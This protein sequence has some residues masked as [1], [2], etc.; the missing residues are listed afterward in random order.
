MLAGLLALLVGYVSYNLGVTYI[1]SYFDD[2]EV[3]RK[4]QLQYLEDL[5][6]FIHENDV[7]V[8]NISKIQ[9]WVADNSYV[10]LSIYRNQKIIYNSDSIYDD[11]S[12]DDTSESE[13]EYSDQDGNA[14]EQEEDS[15]EYL[16]PIVLK[17]SNVVNVDIFCYDYWKYNY[18]ILGMALVFAT[19]VF[20][21]VLTML[22]HRK[23]RYINEI[24]KELQILEGGNL[25]YPITIKGKDEIANLAC[26]IEQM[27]ISIIENIEKEQQ[28]LR[29][30][31]E[32]V[33][34]M[35]H[36]LR[37]PLTILTGYLEMLNMGNIVDEEKRKHYLELSLLKSQEIRQLSDDLFEYFLIYGESE[38]HIDVEP[39]PAND[40]VEDLM[41]NQMLGL[42]EEGYQ[43][44]DMN[45]LHADIGNCMI[46]IKYMQ[47][48]L[49][50]II[51]NL[52]K[53]AAKDVPIRIVANVEDNKLILRVRNKICINV[54]P[55]ESTKIG[56][57]TCERIMKLHHGE[58]K[59]HEENGEF[60]VK[61]TIPMEE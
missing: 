61:L 43:F 27:R 13:V 9:D 8:D 60:T 32:L 37:T 31:K 11:A 57:I 21:Y 16:Y 20:A 36:D 18:F 4:M 53:Y 40:L 48:V 59:K 54:E 7:R 52:Q 39:I 23:I 41:Y 30:N 51:S 58:F 6:Q 45:Y 50:N 14:L 28:M 55:H 33:T 47:R 19:L 10:Y 56:L 26:G 42:E 2:Q 22:I 1:D 29:S 46:N 35:S 3:S 44:E 25:E 17:D 12:I 38:K 24:S 5:K 15:P 34:S 49:N